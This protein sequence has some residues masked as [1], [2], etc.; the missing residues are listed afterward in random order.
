MG[1]ITASGWVSAQQRPDG[2]PEKGIQRIGQ[3]QSQD[4]EGDVGVD[5]LEL[6]GTAG[7]A[8]GQHQEQGRDAERQ[9]HQA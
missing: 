5:Q 7:R 6:Q 8:E 1:S 9:P 4:A 2:R 3:D